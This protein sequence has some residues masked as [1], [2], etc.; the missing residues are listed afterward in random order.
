M[1]EY[2]CPVRA[3]RLGALIVVCSNWFSAVFHAYQAELF[4]TEARGVGPGFCYHAAAAIGSLMPI[5]I[6]S[7]R[8][9]GMDLANAMSI[10]I[11]IAL[12]CSAAFIWFGPETRGRQLTT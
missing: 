3:C 10:P 5:L 12:S 8:D 2:S 11:A 7:L 4:P 9:N 1:H 6:G